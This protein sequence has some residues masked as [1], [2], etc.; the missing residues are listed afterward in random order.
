MVPAIMIGL[1]NEKLVPWTQRRP[2][3]AGP[4]FLHWMNVAIPDTNS[5][6]ETR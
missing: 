3:P 1:M 6:I 4:A 2:Q 5:D